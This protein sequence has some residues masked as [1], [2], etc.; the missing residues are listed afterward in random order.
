MEFEIDFVLPW[1]NGNNANWQRNF[2]RVHDQSRVDEELN[3]VERYRTSENSLEIWLKGILKYAN[4]VRYIF[5]VVDELNI[6][7]V[8]IN[9]SSKIKIIPHS[10]IMPRNTLPVFNS[11]T[12]ELNIDNIADL[13]EHFVLFNDDCFVIDYV[14]PDDFFSGFGIPVDASRV[15]RAT[16]NT[17][18][19]KVLMNDMS[20]IF[21]FYSMNSRLN[22]LRMLG[23]IR[24]FSHDFWQSLVTVL[25]YKRVRWY[26]E[27]LPVSYVKSEISNFYENY[28][29]VRNNQ[30]SKKFRSVNDI[31]HRVFR[32]WR[33]AS[34]EY[35]R[36]EIGTLGIYCELNAE[37]HEVIQ[38]S[39]KK[40]YK[41]ICVND[42]PM[43]K[44]VYETSVRL[45]KKSLGNLYG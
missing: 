45:M 8:P 24:F 14:Q 40:G 29:E 36:R 22:R 3:G 16:G 10:S 37:I 43:K 21:S 38:G 33:L 44:E 39:R 23:R 28:P 18:Y 31:S 17:K 41:I 35:K 13:A 15:I 1:V 19:E 5:I 27:H 20:I 25:L 11:N 4:W 9:L 32:F 42:V 12:I 6:P 26:D 2:K 7:D 30:N 34:K